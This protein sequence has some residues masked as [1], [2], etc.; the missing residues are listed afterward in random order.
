MANIEAYKEVLGKILD[1]KVRAFGAELV[2]SK[3][4]SVSGLKVDDEGKVVSLSGNPKSV[5]N[6][7]LKKFEEIA[8]S[9]ST[10]S[11]R[12]AI[13]GTKRKYPNLDLPDALK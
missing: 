10:I 6:S 9:V 4:S 11:A 1:G 7:L 3:A 12:T 5:I 2:V 13:I 8:G